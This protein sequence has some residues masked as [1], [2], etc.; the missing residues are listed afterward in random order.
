MELVDDGQICV[1][2]IDDD[3][4]MRDMITNF[5]LLE[6]HQVVMAESAEEGLNLLPYYTFQV[7]FLDHNLPK[8]EGLVLGEYF[9]NNNP[10]MKVA[11]VTGE[12]DPKLR[13]T[14]ENLD[15]TFI[16]K[17][18]ELPTLLTVIDSYV[19][20]AR[21]RQKRQAD[22]RDRH[23][24]PDFSPYLDAIGPYYS[25]PTIPDRITTQLTNKLK[26]CF[27]NLR[28]VSRYSE[29]DRVA[30]LAALLTAQVLS[31]KLPKHQGKSPFKVFDDLMR[32]Y[33]KRCEFDEAGADE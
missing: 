19:E 3:P 24:V 30:A 14:A 17:P 23:F 29:R 33:G 9:K 16:E 10:Y 4:N 2:V 32:Q 13:V 21:Q 8:M 26:E 20:A 27:N 25:M 28:S 1:L 7:A 12:T 6:G 5:L 15:I 11:L 31:I 18:F 22:E